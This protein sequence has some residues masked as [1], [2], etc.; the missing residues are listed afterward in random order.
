MENALI[1]FSD[2]IHSPHPT[3][4]KMPCKAKPDMFCPNAITHN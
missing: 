1:G 4:L 2:T 3:Y